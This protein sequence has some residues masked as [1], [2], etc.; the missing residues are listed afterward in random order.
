MWGKNKTAFI[1]NA[2]LL[3]Q[4]KKTILW[5]FNTIFRWSPTFNT[6]DIVLRMLKKWKNISLH[7]RPLAKQNERTNTEALCGSFSMFKYRI[8]I[9]FQGRSLYEFSALFLAFF[10]WKPAYETISSSVIFLLLFNDPTVKRL[11]NIN[12][13]TAWRI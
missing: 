7:F 3:R 6:T 9:T 12:E 13:Y 2:V 10:S 8:F 4:K 11:Y 1:N 5:K